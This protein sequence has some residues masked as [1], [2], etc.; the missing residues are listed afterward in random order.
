M[1]YPKVERENID[2]SSDSNICNIGYNEGVLKDGRP[3]RLEVWSSNRIDTCTIFISNKDLED[4]SDVDLVKYIANE[5]LI[6]IDDDRVTVNEYTDINDNT[7]YSINLVLNNKDE[8][9][10]KL[11]V[12][13]NNYDY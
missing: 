3:Y 2:F 12:S 4:K 13:L 7:F 9:I 6:D 1:E 8:E 11:L 5:G 10:N